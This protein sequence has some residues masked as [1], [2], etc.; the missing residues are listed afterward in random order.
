MCAWLAEQEPEALF[1]C[2][3]MAQMDRAHAPLSAT[4]SG[5][6]AVMLGRGQQ[7]YLLWFRKEQPR[8]VTWAGNPKKP[9]A[10]GNDPRDLSPRRSFAAWR[11][12]VRETA[13]P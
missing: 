2:A 11:E 5:V 6:L 12:L 9:F 3:A 13:K 1:H 10:I 7:E 8:T 4:A